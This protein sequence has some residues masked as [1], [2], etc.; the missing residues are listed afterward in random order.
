MKC[1]SWL[2]LIHLRKQWLRTLIQAIYKFLFKNE[3]PNTGM[4]SSQW[5]W[6]FVDNS[7]VGLDL[8]SMDTD[9]IL[10][11]IDQIVIVDSATQRTADKNFE[12][13]CLDS[14]ID[15]EKTMIGVTSS[16]YPSPSTSGIR[17]FET[18]SLQ[19][20]RWATSRLGLIT[21]KTNK[22]STQ[23]HPRVG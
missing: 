17:I 11:F 6:Y 10:A 3:I 1:Y 12:F 21:T 8:Q 22:S 23:T 2:I 9:G 18:S 14:D 20:T 7:S 16:P 4:I 19:E 5:E 15:E 13:I